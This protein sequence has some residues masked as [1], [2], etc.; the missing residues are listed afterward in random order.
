MPFQKWTLLD[1]VKLIVLSTISLMDSTNLAD[2]RQ[3]L[4]LK[5]VNKWIIESIVYGTSC[6]TIRWIINRNLS[7]SITNAQT[8][9]E[10][11]ETESNYNQS[12]GSV[13]CKEIILMCII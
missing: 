10:T 3:N 6:K 8:V 5:T 13:D 2:S 11:T 12:S 7:F 4:P 1:S 9:K